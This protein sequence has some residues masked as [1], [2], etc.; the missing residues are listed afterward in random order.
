LNEFLSLGNDK[1]GRL[2]NLSTLKNP[3]NTYFEG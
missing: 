3:M 2:K 1:F